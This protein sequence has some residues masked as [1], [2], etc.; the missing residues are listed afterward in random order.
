LRGNAKLTAALSAITA[1]VVGVV[2]NLAVWFGLHVLF[3]GGQPVNW[4][5]VVV[6]V[7]AFIGMTKWKWDIIP[8][9]L[10]AGLLGLIYKT[11]F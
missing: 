4:F 7:I 1:A 2:L 8:V 11:V 9:V 5:G 6:C 10:G 3:P